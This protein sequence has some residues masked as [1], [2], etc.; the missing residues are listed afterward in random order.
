[1][2][3]VL[4]VALVAVAPGWAIVRHLPLDDPLARVVLSVTVGVA[5]A[6]G[7]AGF[8]MYAGWW[9]PGRAATI[10][11]LVTLGAATAKGHGLRW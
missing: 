1:M 11:V 8:L 6:T 4:A 2:R 5:V 10:L 9:S 7:V 3:L